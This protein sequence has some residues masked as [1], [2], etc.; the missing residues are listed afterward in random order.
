MPQVVVDTVD[1]LVG[2]S[3]IF[4]SVLC[5]ADVLYTIRHRKYV[6]TYEQN[7]IIRL[8]ARRARLPFAPAIIITVVGECAL[9]LGM[10]PLVLSAAYGGMFDG[11]ILYWHVAGM[12]AAV[13]CA[14]HVS[15]TL[16]SRRFVNAQ[17]VGKKHG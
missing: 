4:W 16:Q 13:G 14:A 15:A 9:V 11:D 8:L 12:C 7:P 1:M 10:A 6:R 3:I 2:C 17:T 5:L